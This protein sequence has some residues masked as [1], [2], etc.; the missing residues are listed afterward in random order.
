MIFTILAILGWV[1]VLFLT[2]VCFVLLFAIGAQ[3][4]Q[5]SEKLEEIDYL[6]N[7]LNLENSQSRDNLH[8]SA[9]MLRS[10]LAKDYL[11]NFEKWNIKKFR[12]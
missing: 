4:A 6:K 10:E 7:R 11:R 5:I 9:D 3:Q 1:A 8:K 12:D 2:C